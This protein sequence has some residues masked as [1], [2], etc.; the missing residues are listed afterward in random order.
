MAETEELARESI[1]AGADSESEGMRPLRA[2]DYSFNQIGISS[3]FMLLSN[4]PADLA[5]EKGFYPVGGCGGNSNA[6]HTE[7]DTLD[8]AD[9]DNLLR[10]I[11]VYVEAVVRLATAPFLPFDH[12]AAVHEIGAAVTEYA[13]A[14]EGVLDIEPV[15]AECAALIADLDEFYELVERAVA[16]ADDAHD[17]AVDFDW[18]QMALAREL[19]PV[20]YARR[21][22]YHDP[23]LE[24][25]AVPDLAILRQWAALEDD[26]DGRGFLIAQA[27]RGRNRVVDALKRARERV[28][29]A[30]PAE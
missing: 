1:R 21:R 9:A 11:H 15:L 7:G 19:V 6:W 4:I 2:G 28:S 23:A 20:N 22:Y 26:P 14:C 8:V 24:T 27:L 30:L 18:V 25:P 5:A 12:R 3:F 16:E 29:G 10:D 17:A 13:E